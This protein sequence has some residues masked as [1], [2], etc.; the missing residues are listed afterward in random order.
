MKPDYPSKTPP[1]RFAK[2]WSFSVDDLLDTDTLA[3]EIDSPDLYLTFELADKDHIQQSLALL[4][5]GTS[6]ECKNGKPEKK[7]DPSTDELVLG[8]FGHANVFLLKDDEVCP[9]FFL[10]VGGRSKFKVR[11]RLEGDHLQ[12]FIEA[13]KS[14]VS[15]ELDLHFPVYVPVRGSDE[16]PLVS[17]SGDLTDLLPI[18]TSR[19]LAELYI[20]QAGRDLK[21]YVLPDHAA[22]SRH[23]QSMIEAAGVTHYVINFTFS[24]TSVKVG[25]VADLLQ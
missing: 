23:V 19:E 20:E 4:A 7:F 3:L 17:D 5:S 13:L 14:A 12:G 1:R 11:V 2:Q 16:F 15:D 10:I 25:D 6:A 9:R 22:L 21:L 24:P 18:F 8:R